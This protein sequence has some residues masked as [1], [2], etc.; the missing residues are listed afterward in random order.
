MTSAHLDT[1]TRDNL[2][3][4]E[5]W[6]ELIFSLPE[7]AYPPVLNCADFLLDRVAHRLGGDRRCLV[8]PTETW[9]YADLVA[10]SNQVANVL[11]EDLGLV[12]GNRVLLRGPN[13][14]WLIACWFGVMKAGGVAVPTM[15]LLRSR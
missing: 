14:P 9:T 13:N 2:P 12:S 8:T 1:F 7:L 10:R 5:T 11:V 4:P 15:P 3:D 6:P